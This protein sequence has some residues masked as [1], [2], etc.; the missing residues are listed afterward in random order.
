MSN[1]AIIATV[2]TKGEEVAY[3]KKIIEQ[4]GHNSK[5]IDV[6]ILGPPLNEPDVSNEE[7]AR[8]G[9]WDL[10]ELTK[11]KKRDQIIQ[12]MGEGAARCLEDLYNNHKVD[13]V[14]GIGGNQGTAI[15]SI[16]MKVLPIGF[17]KCI[18]STVV[19]GNIRP[20]IGNKDILILFSVADFIGGPNIVTKTILSN[21]IDA[22][23]GMV[24]FDR[25]LQS[26]FQKTVAISALGNTELAV[27]YAI[28]CLKEKGYH[29]IPFHASG[30]GGSAME[31]LMGYGIISAVLDITPHELSEEVVG[32]G[33]YIPVKSGRLTVA[34][35]LGLP[36]VV[37]T[38]AL[39]YLCFGPMESIPVQLR[40]RKIYMH[41]PY[42]AN[43][44]LSI[45]EMG[46]IGQVMAERLNQA[47]GPVAVLIPLKGW[48]IYGSIG[49]P[50]Y[51]PKGNRT[52]I[53]SLKKHLNP[54]IYLEEVDAHINEPYF[55]DK[56]INILINLMKG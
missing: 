22:L 35:R 43:V 38:G 55:I 46:K 12:I 31:E 10:K 28:K 53:N 11:I 24:E 15:S 23:I 16:A 8:L 19:S 41:N 34:G 36:Q 49:G 50:L 54:N 18:V 29:P 21:A 47:K 7:I 32:L 48:S 44:R 37:S 13:G 45:K 25:G 33:A 39:E 20:F 42:N 51:N 52:L 2:D 26:N 17:P 5:V 30:A 9:G 56:C 4:R 40:R 27:K 3:L 1:I 6:G 14:I